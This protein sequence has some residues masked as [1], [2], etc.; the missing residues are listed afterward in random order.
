MLVKEDL[1]I[2]RER[3]KESNGYMCV[4]ERIAKINQDRRT[5]IMICSS[6]I[7]IKREGFLS[8]C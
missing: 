5:C 7:I 1:M 6:K 2:K 4:K 8:I 3:E